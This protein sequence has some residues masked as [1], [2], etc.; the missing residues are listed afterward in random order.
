[1]VFRQRRAVYYGKYIFSA[2]FPRPA[3]FCV[4]SGLI[5]L[6]YDF[7]GEIFL[8]FLIFSAALRALSGKIDV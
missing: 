4:Q 7:R 3:I 6:Y 8:F 5:V 1:M 2:Y